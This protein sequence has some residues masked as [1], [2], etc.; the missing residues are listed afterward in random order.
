MTSL[1][2]SAVA[3]ASVKSSARRQRQERVSAAR[4]DDTIGDLRQRAQ[5]PGRRKRVAGHVRRQAGGAQD[6]Q[7]IDAR[8]RQPLAAGLLPHALRN[9]V[10]CLAERKILRTREK[11]AQQP[12]AG[13]GMLLGLLD[14]Q[15]AGGGGLYVAALQEHGPRPHADEAAHLTCSVDEHA[16]ARLAA[17][18]FT[19]E[20]QLVEILHQPV[21]RRA[22]LL[23]EHAREHAG[24]SRNVLTSAGANSLS[25]GQRSQ[26]AISY[27]P[28]ACRS[29]SG[30]NAASVTRR[31]RRSF[32]RSKGYARAT[33]VLAR[34]AREGGRHFVYNLITRI[35]RAASS[36]SGRAHWIA[37]E[38]ARKIRL[39][40]AVQR[41]SHI[42]NGKAEWAAAAQQ[43][44]D[45]CLAKREP[46]RPRKALR[47][48]AE[49]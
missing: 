7:P 36:G 31:R 34:S 4:L 28:W 30:S 2:S 24:D 9:V 46:D 20:H 16:R 43:L 18:E 5:P 26:P 21:G 39:N 11:C 15:R 48:A 33:P 42:A 25:H 1:I 14:H 8:R 3:S 47:S 6:A 32:E 35:N 44:S 10:R 37:R 23:Q 49:R 40:C 45:A 17:V 41:R 27:P 13:Y 12:R 38:R 19:V 22:S 29:A